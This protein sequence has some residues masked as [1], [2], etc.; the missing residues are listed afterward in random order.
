[1]DSTIVVHGGAGAWDVVSLE[2][3]DKA[4]TAC[5]AAT[6]AGQKILRSGGMALDA[7]EAAVRVL[8]DSPIL[9]AGRGRYLNAAGQIEMEALI[10]D[11]ANMAL[12][13]PPALLISSTVLFAASRLRSPIATLAPASASLRAM[14]LPIPMISLDAN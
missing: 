13:L 12:A 11:G 8:E 3:L 4:V 7:V 5:V 6:K 2:R 9:D 14:P 1:M 10:M